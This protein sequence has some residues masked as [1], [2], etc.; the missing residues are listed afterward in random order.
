MT[1][2]KLNASLHRS[3]DKTEYIRVKFWGVP[4]G[5]NFKKSAKDDH[6]LIISSVKNGCPAEGRANLS[7]GDAIIAI[8]NQDV[9]GMLAT[10]VKKLIR[11]EVQAQGAHS[12][13]E[14]PPMWHLTFRRGNP[15]KDSLQRTPSD[16]WK[17]SKTIDA[18][19]DVFEIN[20]ATSISA[21][22]S[23]PPKPS[24]LLTKVTPV[25]QEVQERRKVARSGDF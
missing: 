20:H 2:S 13:S 25:V 11:K 23:K 21:K 17:T 9:R 16:L 4:T 14:A 8:G 5:L 22:P 7:F 10:E 6:I 12:T 1:L 19:D 3:R 24:K 15:P 18:L